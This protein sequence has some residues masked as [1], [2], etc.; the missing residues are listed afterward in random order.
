[1]FTNTSYAE[2]FAYGQ[3][4][5]GFLAELCATATTIEDIDWPRADKL[6]EEYDIKLTF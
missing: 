2:A 3:L 6:L 1:M 5:A 4:Q